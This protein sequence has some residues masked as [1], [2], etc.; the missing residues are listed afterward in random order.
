MRPTIG[1]G[2]AI[3]ALAALSCVLVSNKKAVAAV[4][5][6]PEAAVA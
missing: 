6:A 3:L 5:A 2:V 4:P 1:V